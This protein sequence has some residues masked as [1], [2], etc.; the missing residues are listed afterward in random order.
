VKWLNPLSWFRASRAAHRSSKYVAKERLKLA[1]TYD[2]GGIA[3]GTIEQLQDEI[4]QLLV[5]HLAV[6]EEDIQLQF[7]RTAEC[8]KLIAS[9]PLRPPPQSRVRMTGTSISESAPA[10]SRRQRSR[11]AK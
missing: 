4:L 2:R 5:K 11:P 1:L 7:D 9:I 6:R 8:D 3:R 10:Q